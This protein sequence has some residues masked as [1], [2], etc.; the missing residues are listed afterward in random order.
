[1]RPKFSFR[2]EETYQFLR[3][4]LRFLI[5]IIPVMVIPI[6]D[7]ELSIFYLFLL[8]LVNVIYFVLIDYLVSIIFGGDR[9]FA[10]RSSSDGKAGQN[11]SRKTPYF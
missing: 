9:V 5:F 7:L 1:M 10:R 6:L 2:I 11:K 4:T 8:G 3:N